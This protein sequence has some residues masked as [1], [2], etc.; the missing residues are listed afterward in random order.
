MSKTISRMFRLL[1]RFAAGC[2]MAETSLPRKPQAA[3]GDGGERLQHRVD[4]AFGGVRATS[5]IDEE[6][7]APAL[8]AVRRLAG[9]ESLQISPPSSRAGRAPVR[10]GFSDLRVTTTMTSKRSVA[11]VSKRSGTSTTTSRR[12]PARAFRQKRLLTLPHER[13]H[14]RLEPRQGRRIADDPLGKTRPVDGAVRR[15]PRKRRLDR[16]DRL[17]GIEAVDG[18]V[19]TS[20]PARRGARTS[21]R[22]CSFPCRSI[23]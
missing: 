10:A 17:A 2:K 1:V 12:P 5:R 19:G 9:K 22:S 11:P 6:V 13:M 23:R 21:P 18:R 8:F 14:D 4:L 3:S 15:H 7:G 16:G 20:A